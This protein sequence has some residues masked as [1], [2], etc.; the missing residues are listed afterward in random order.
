M[1]K[2]RHKRRNA[3]AR[4][5]L[6][7]FKTSRLPRGSWQARFEDLLCFRKRHPAAWP[8]KSYVSADGF[9][10][11]HWCRDQ[12]KARRRGTLRSERMQ[13]LD[14]IGFLWE[15]EGS[16]AKWEKGFGELARW[17][18]SRPEVW[19]TARYVAPNGYKL[20]SWCHKQRKLR[21][22]GELAR[23]RIQ[24]LGEIGFPW[25]LKAD[26][27]L[28]AFAALKVFCQGHRHA[29]PR[30]FYVTAGGLKLGYWLN[31]A[32]VRM[33]TGILPKARVRALQNIGVRF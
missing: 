20:G 11:G 9:R 18:R 4:T 26:L 19:P 30:R 29:W 3:V 17:R 33:R 14:G 5:S 1:P 25:I 27:W 16:Q 8:A 32:H 24:R 22:K 28:E 31:N 12:R 15:P 6:L 23:A 13:Q 7:S 2:L 10:L 21:S